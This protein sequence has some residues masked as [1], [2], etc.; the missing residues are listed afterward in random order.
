MIQGKPIL[1]QEQLLR[2]HGVYVESLYLHLTLHST[3]LQDLQSV[4]EIIETRYTF[5][6]KSTKRHQTW[7]KLPR[8]PS[9]PPLTQCCAKPEEAMRGSEG[10]K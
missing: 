9:P 4:T 3:F 2:S 10:Q 7:L 5:I 8:I 1:R 6:K